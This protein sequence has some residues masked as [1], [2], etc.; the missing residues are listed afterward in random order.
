[1]FV[2]YAASSAARYRIRRI[3]RMYRTP[4]SP[5]SVPVS[6]E[7]PFSYCANLRKGIKGAQ[8]YDVLIASVLEDLKRFSEELRNTFPHRYPTFELTM[9]ETEAEVGFTV[10]SIVLRIPSPSIQTA[11]HQSGTDGTVL[12]ATLRVVVNSITMSL[13]SPH[14]LTSW[15]S[16]ETYLALGGFRTVF[17]KFLERRETGRLL[18]SVLGDSTVEW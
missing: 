18:C 4:P 6:A 8:R 2:R 13:S 11:E 16:H 14:L 1:M 12:L 15:D 3:T 17:A 9:L 10:Y 7:P 5:V